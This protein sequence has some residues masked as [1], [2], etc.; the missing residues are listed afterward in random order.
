[1]KMKTVY[2]QDFKSLSEY[3]KTYQ[4]LNKSSECK[5]K[6][7]DGR[8]GTGWMFFDSQEEMKTHKNQR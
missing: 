7:D 1:M 4:Y 6:V 5:I 3:R 2:K 8:G